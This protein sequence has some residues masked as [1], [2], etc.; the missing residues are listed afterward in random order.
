[1][2]TDSQ[3]GAERFTVKGQAMGDLTFDRRG[4]LGTGTVG[5]FALAAPLS[6]LMETQ[7]RAEVGPNGEQT[8]L[9]ASPY[10]PVQP[11]PDLS[12]GLPLLQL[13]SGFAY[14]SISWRGDLMSDGQRV[15][16]GHDGMAVVQVTGGRTPEHILIRNHE[17]TNGI[18]QSVIGNDRA[19]YNPLAT[20]G[21]GC[22]VLRVKG[23]VVSDHRQA[24]AGTAQNCAGGNTLW[25]SWLTC[26]ETNIAGSSTA[27]PHGYVFDVSSDPRQTMAQP[28][29]EMGRFAHEA[30]AMDPRTGYVYMTED[31]SPVS[32]FYRFKP[33]STAR[34]YGALSQGG[35][36]QMAK[37]IGVDKANLLGLS[38]RGET[39][40]ERVG[41]TLAVEWVNIENPDANARSITVSPGEVRTVSGPF[42]EGRDKGGLRMSRGEGIWYDGRGTFYVVDTSFGARSLGAVWAYVPSPTNPAV[43]QL[44]LIFSSSVSVVGNNPDNITVSPSGGVVFCEDGGA[45]TDQFGVGMRMMGLTRS[46]EAYILA[47]NNVTLTAA[48]LASMGRTGHPFNPGAGDYRNTEFA[49]AT[50]DPTGRILYVNTQAPGITFAIAG[51]W[52]RGNL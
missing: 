28:I 15:S 33:T 23:G 14:R 30:I 5:A 6:G 16:P 11:T 29:K 7:A 25:N 42:A 27:L 51:P 52:A 49:G 9:A 8:A 50:F 44:T 41:Q 13:P 37:I 21:G 45:R 1:M 18:R 2:L 17:I 31:A 12:T 10:G 34:A 19:V 48:Q 47:K 38:G 39:A 36:L 3:T 46:G 22:S 40:V 20:R 32:G 26:E 4:F 43:G 24:I 35:V